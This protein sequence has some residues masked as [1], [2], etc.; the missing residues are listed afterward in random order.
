MAQALIPFENTDIVGE[1]SNSETHGGEDVAL[2][3]IGPGS[4]RVGG[5]MEQSRIYGIIM[6]AFGQ[7]N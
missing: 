1:V 6:D 3:A 7:E 5:V 4:D 2:Y